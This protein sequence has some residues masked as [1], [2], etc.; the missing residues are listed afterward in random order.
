MAEKFKPEL[1][2]QCTNDECDSNNGSN[3]MFTVELTVDE[4]GDA[5][6]SSKNIAGK[7]HSC[8]HCDSVARWVEPST[9]CMH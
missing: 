6:D 5:I 1:Q 4:H 2:L 9:E 3:P 8:C 7:Y